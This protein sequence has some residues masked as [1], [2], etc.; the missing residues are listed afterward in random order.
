[1]DSIYFVCLSAVI[2]IILIV[3]LF[4]YL[5][6][7]PSADINNQIS[8]IGGIAFAFI[9][10]GLIMGNDRITTYS[11]FSIG[12]ILCLVDIYIRLKK[13]NNPKKKN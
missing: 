9:L 10:L 7:R 13:K 11:F 6:K 5:K 12:I 1:M 4:I 8:P 2:L 3:L